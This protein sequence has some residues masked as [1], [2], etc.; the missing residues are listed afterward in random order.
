M[1]GG[2]GGFIQNMITSLRDNRNLLRKRNR[3]HRDEDIEFSRVEHK[4]PLIF[5]KASDELLIE[6]KEKHK[7]KKKLNDLLTIF[8]VLLAASFSMFVLLKSAHAPQ[9]SN[10]DYFAFEANGKDLS[11]KE[12]LFLFF[13][14]DG[15]YWY[16]ESHFKNAVFQYQNALKLYPK[17]E[18]VL[19]RLQTT[20]DLAC[21]REALFC[22]EWRA[23][24]RK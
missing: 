16:T 4:E 20:Y 5:K 23:G 13:I 17:N 12:E 6:I 11:K 1:P 24:L 14:E 21:E 18:A 22:E 15:D 3:F 19:Q 7:R 8:T 9:E 2:A 10:T